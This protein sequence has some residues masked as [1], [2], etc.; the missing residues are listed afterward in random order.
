MEKAVVLVSGGINSAVAAATAREQYHPALLHV[1]WGHRSAERE[2]ACFER[3]AA[4]M[5]IET[6]L[7]A[8]LPCMAA[9]G[10]SARVSR[11]HAIEDA[12]TLGRGTP[13]T[14]TPGLMPAML[15]LAAAWAGAIGA[16]H[17]VVG[18][19]EDHRVPGPVISELYPDYR[20]ELFQSFNILLHYGKPANR[21]LQV[22][23]P[24]IDLA[25]AEVVRLGEL[26]GVPFDRTWSCYAD[27]KTPC[28]RCLGCTTRA[29]GFLQARIPDPL[30]LEPVAK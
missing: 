1:A 29:N 7:V 22:E 13:A 8:E 16:R 30:L 15:S 3:L 9:F 19:S 4:A 18:V 20:R 5:N 11:R 23:T 21:D 24:L 25:R 17:I 26:A 12:G 28:N 2:L 10:G 14:F 6:T 27:N